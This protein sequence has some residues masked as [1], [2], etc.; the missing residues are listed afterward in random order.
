[1]KSKINYTS[2][3]IMMEI[4]LKSRNFEKLQRFSA[5]SRKSEIRANFIKSVKI[6]TNFENMQLFSIYNV[7]N[8]KKIDE[9]LLKY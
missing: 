9:I 8:A 5:F 4:E 6:A 2:G 3:I 1:M 7:E